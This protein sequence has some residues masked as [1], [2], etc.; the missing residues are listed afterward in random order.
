MPREFMFGVTMYRKSVKIII[1][2]LISVS[3]LLTSQVLALRPTA[4]A[5]S[6]S[7]GQLAEDVTMSESLLSK[8]RQAQSPDPD[9]SLFDQ[10]VQA[11][12]LKRGYEVYSSRTFSEH[13]WRGEV[14]LAKKIATGEYVA[15]KIADPYGDTMVPEVVHAYCLIMDSAISFWKSIDLL[16]YERWDYPALV[17]LYEAGAIPTSEL[18]QTLESIPRKSQH[19]YDFLK[20]RLTWDYHYQIME[21]FDDGENVEE[22]IREGRFKDA[23]TAS[24]IES[25][26]DFM[27]RLDAMHKKGVAHGELLPKNLMADKNLYLKACDLDPI[28]VI[29]RTTFVDEHQYIMWQKDQAYIRSTAQQMLMQAGGDELNDAMH[30]FFGK[31]TRE[32]I[33]EERSRLLEF[34]DALLEFKARLASEAGFGPAA[35]K[36]LRL[37]DS[38]A[39]RP[40]SHR[41]S[42]RLAPADRAKAD[43]IIKEVYDSYKKSAYS[44]VANSMLRDPSFVA[45]AF[46]WNIYFLLAQANFDNAV[47]NPG[48]FVDIF[49]RYYPD[50]TDE[51]RLVFDFLMERMNLEEFKDIYWNALVYFKDGDNHWY[52]TT[53][54]EHDIIR[55]YDE[56][57]FHRRI[58]QIEN[59]VINLEIM[60]AHFVGKNSV[61][62]AE[63][64]DF[65][66]AT[67]EVNRWITEGIDIT[68]APEIFLEHLCRLHAIAMNRARE[69]KH[70]ESIIIVDGKS[71]FRERLAEHT[72]RPRAYPSGQQVGPL[73]DVF[74]KRVGC[75]D[76]KGRNPIMQASEA[77]LTLLDIHPFP[78]GNR[79]VM[80]LILNYL[81]MRN[82]IVPLLIKPENIDDYNRVLRFMKTDEEFATF[83]VDQLGLE[84]HFYHEHDYVTGEVDSTK[85]SS[86]GRQNSSNVTIYN[87][88]LNERGAIRLP[89][90]LQRRGLNIQLLRGGVRFLT[91]ENFDRLLKRRGINVDQPLFS[92]RDDLRNIRDLINARI[93]PEGALSLGADVAKMVGF[94]PPCRVELVMPAE[95]S[96]AAKDTFCLMRVPRSENALSSIYLIDPKAESRIDE[97][98]GLL[99]NGSISVDEL[100]EEARA[101]DSGLEVT[102]YLLQK[103]ESAR[104]KTARL[105]EL[106]SRAEAIVGF[107]SGMV[108]M[109]RD[110]IKGV[111]RRVKLAETRLRNGETQRKLELLEQHT[112]TRERSLRALA[113]KKEELK[114]SE[115]EHAALTEEMNRNNAFLASVADLIIRI[116]IGRNRSGIILVPTLLYSDELQDHEIANQI[117]TG[118]ED[119]SYSA[120]ATAGSLASNQSSRQRCIGLLSQMIQ[121]KIEI[122]RLIEVYE[123]SVSDNIRDTI[124][125]AFIASG[126]ASLEHLQRWY[127]NK[128]SRRKP[129]VEELLLRIRNI[130]EESASAFCPFAS[131]DTMLE[132]HR[133][134]NGIDSAA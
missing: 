18:L 104:R 81:L 85:S 71:Q 66:E 38:S 46:D 25:L 99:A 34:A 50:I 131:L 119:R 128:D 33:S 52:L 6:S 93:S 15:I 62:Q 44:I 41:L 83:L 17:Q 12:F 31:W 9:A 94:T 49:K 21:F 115:I 55:S 90:P 29:D 35:A 19:Q 89:K 51:A 67:K 75:D 98:L 14:F 57:V 8:I 107:N 79:R 5:K 40:I 28:G 86:S 114:A 117:L 76:F 77:F 39:L 120:L 134:D 133:V 108:R 109:E 70:G 97:L 73:M 32:Y 45:M 59:P 112:H 63:K 20:E 105:S 61:S 54:I 42:N 103:I 68:E 82:N 129:V 74:A 1:V 3:C 11:I 130:R 88:R 87:L 127:I 65:L 126:D 10:V 113:Q 48:A 118:L 125:E 26:V 37:I 84:N 124:A 58:P 4:S 102:F 122:S 80:K 23:D 123:D 22:L 111:E 100:A 64:E 72:D 91:A 116:N 110:F 56:H 53:K 101:L 30:E 78:N 47:F 2:V 7:A 121:S 60:E 43:Q 69:T 95:D 16:D 36:R 24:L 106:A 96:K 13:G 27:Y 92:G 132:M